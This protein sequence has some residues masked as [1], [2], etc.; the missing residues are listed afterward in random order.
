[1][2]ICEPPTTPQVQHCISF[3]KVP[4]RH[5]LI[6]DQTCRRLSRWDLRYLKAEESDR[7]HRDFIITVCQSTYDETLE[8]FW[9]QDVWNQLEKAVAHV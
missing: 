9:D 7:S 8:I 5:C 6:F 3:V 4:S 2:L 1:M